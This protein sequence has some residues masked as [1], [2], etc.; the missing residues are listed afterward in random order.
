MGDLLSF[1]TGNLRQKGITVNELCEML[2]ISRQK[3][4]RF[5]KEPE[6][7][8]DQNLKDIANILQL[9][10]A[11][12][13]LLRNYLFPGHTPLSSTESPD[14]SAQIKN[15]LLRS[16]AAELSVNLHNIEY[17]DA[18]GTAYMYSPTQLAGAIARAGASDIKRAEKKSGAAGPK[19]HV[20]NITVYNCISAGKFDKADYV[21]S[22]SITTI[23]RLLMS[24]DRLYSNVEPVRMHIRHY[25]SES[26]K[27]SMDDHDSANTADLYFNFNLLN[28]V[29]PLL[30]ASEDYYIETADPAR[31]FWAEYSNICLIE[32]RVVPKDGTSDTEAIRKSHS[33]TPVQYFVLVFSESGECSACHL[34]DRE[35][36]HIYR[37]LSL[38]TRDQHSGLLEMTPAADPNQ[39]F[40]EYAKSL[41]CALIHPDLCFDDIPSE[42]WYALLN[43]VEASESKVLFEAGFRGLMDPYG[44]YSFLDF[45]S[46]VHLAVNTLEQR[47]A[48]NSRGG[49][50][51]ICHP[52]GLQTFV[53]TGIINDLIDDGVDYKGQSDLAASLRFPAPLIKKLLEMIRES[54]VRRQ[55]SDIKD[56]LQYDWVN[57]YILK[58]QYPCP[59][60]TYGVY[61]DFGV[62]AYYTK[63]RYRHVITNSFQNPAIGTTMYDYLLHE[64]VGKRGQKFGSDILSDEHSIALLDKLIRELERENS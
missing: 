47:Y 15:I 59:E 55:N 64:M 54:I 38:D 44:Q 8:S 60:I 51:V 49:K 16:P 34:G 21:P 3:F 50:I 40:F 32:H 26:F 6:R 7:F 36:G 37:F 61:R 27:K 22:K 63:S 11:D 53:R 57:Y 17:I 48:M 12:S 31:H 19:V 20:Y 58:P 28:D 13:K 45:S 2:G 10:E 25:L 5:V 46:L 24:L 30:S 52:E 29:L 18:S 4:Y 9:G 35:A 42:M 33:E 1:I 56:P 39:T 62:F 14:Y 41:K 23:G 43:I